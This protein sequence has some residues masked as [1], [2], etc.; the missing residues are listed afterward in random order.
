MPAVLQ[1]LSVNHCLA[2]P[3][4]N[5]AT[6]DDGKLAFLRIGATKF[7]EI[8]CLFICAF[9]VQQCTQTHMY[10]PSIRHIN[11]RFMLV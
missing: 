3:A 2:R 1:Y 10:L 5:A 8:D 6:N 7:Q 4:K 9:A 11:L